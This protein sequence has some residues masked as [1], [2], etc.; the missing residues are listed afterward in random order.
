MR[1]DGIEILGHTADRI[2]IVSFIDPPY[3]AAGKRAGSRLY[4]HSELNHKEL[5][6]VASTLAGDFL[7]T[8]SDDRQVRELAQQVDFEAIIDLSSG[9]T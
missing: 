3:T 2:D 4:T 5:F 7:M 8:Y 1:A 9:S 6:R